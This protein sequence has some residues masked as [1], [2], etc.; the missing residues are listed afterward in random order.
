MTIE[1]ENL[2]LQ[3][4]EIA[5][6]QV[7]GVRCNPVPLQYISAERS[8]C[9]CVSVCARV[10]EGVRGSHSPC[11]CR[12]VCDMAEALLPHSPG[13]PVELCIG[14]CSAEYRTL[15]TQTYSFV[16]S[17]RETEPASASPCSQEP[18]CCQLGLPA[19]TQLRLELAL[20]M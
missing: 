13:G 10:I 1:G 7:A 18:S 2:G 20:R 9:V 3:V 5:H 12:I 16:V 15:S 14:V 6:V 11:V 19:S 17:V 8:V 4:K